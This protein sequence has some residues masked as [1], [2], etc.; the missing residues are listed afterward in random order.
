[1][2]KRFLYNLFGNLLILTGVLVVAALFMLSSG[3]AKH[4]T[5]GDQ[6]PKGDPGASGVSCTQTLISASHV[7]GDPSE[8]GGTM[9]H[10]SNG[11]VFV[12]NGAPGAPAVG[13]SA[14]Q[15]CPGYTTYPSAFPEFGFCSQGSIYAVY[16]DGHNAWMALV[17]PGYYASTS[18]SAPCNFHVAANCQV[19][20]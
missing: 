3:C 16:W 8:Y 11:D 13:F 15:F 17:A 12:S 10:C 1:M 9:I 18:T 5:P 6:G 4:G 20:P 2:L 7:S 14:I 19:S